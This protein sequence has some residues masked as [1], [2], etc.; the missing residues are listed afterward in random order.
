MSLSGLGGEWSQTGD[1]WADQ[2]IAW[3]PESSLG[4]ALSY[5]VGCSKM[6]SCFAKFDSL[7]ELIAYVIDR[8][9]FIHTKTLVTYISNITGVT[10]QCQSHVINTMEH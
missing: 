8:R 5:L 7:A 10:Y 4:W 6:L 2:D 1:G 9:A 3:L